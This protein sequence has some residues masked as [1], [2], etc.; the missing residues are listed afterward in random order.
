MTVAELIEA[1]Q[2]IEDKNTPVVVLGYEGGLRDVSDVASVQMHLNVNTEWF[3][4][5]HEKVYSQE[6]LENSVT[7]VRIC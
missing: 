2:Q 6:D 1:L 3:Y 7:G 5:P 4:G